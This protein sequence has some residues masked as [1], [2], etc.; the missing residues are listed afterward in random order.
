M[1]G[2][3]ASYSIIP[4]DAS[5]EAE[6]EIRSLLSELAEEFPKIDELNI[7]V[8]PGG[9]NGLILIDL[10]DFV[11]GK[12]EKFKKML[13]KRVFEKFEEMRRRG[14][15]RYIKKLV[16]L[17]Y[18]VK[19]DVEEVMEVVR[20]YKDVIGDRWRITLKS[21][22]VLEDKMSFIRKVAEPI[23]K[24]VDLKNPKYIIHIEVLGELTG[25][26]LEIKE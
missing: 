16:I 11:S 18:L 25:V 15:I 1:E 4:Y 26:Y 5:F 14:D 8:S 10:R 13:R 24:Q 22:G 20:K 17:D 21:R 2:L 6:Y 23:D 7:I 3:L 19:T 9:F 12:D